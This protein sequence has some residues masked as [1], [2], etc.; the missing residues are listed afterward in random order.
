VSFDPIA[1][2]YRALETIAFGNALQQARVACLDEIGSPRRALIV[3]EGNG[4]FLTAL[5]QR[6]PL[7]RVDCVDS[8]QQMLDLAERRVLQTDPDAIRR[9]AFLR[10]DVLSWRPN[11]RYDLIVTHFLLDGF[12]TR[13]VGLIV[14]KLAQAAASQ[15][16][17]LLADFRLPETGFARL[18]ARAWLAAMYW[19]FRGVAGIEAH[20]LVDP[21]PFLLAE[22]FTRRRQQLFRNGM[23]K[24]ELWRNNP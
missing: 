16:I 14:A 17:W 21:S 5:L 20:E 6:Q 24:S 15:A 1:P 3:G 13:H 12:R 7:I 10:H 11:D 4:R 2:W 8:S 9:V 23:L 18:H 19:F 22:G